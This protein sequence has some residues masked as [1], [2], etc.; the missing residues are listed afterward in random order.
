MNDKEETTYSMAISFEGCDPS[1]SFVAG[2]ECGMID[3]M[4]KN[5]EPIDRT[6]H[7]INE[8]QIRR[9]AHYYDYKIGFEPTAPSDDPDG[10][11]LFM[12]AAPVPAGEKIQ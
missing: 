9:I 7:R 10:T 3:Q 11:W 1:P 6:V 12:K 5:G 8:E 2:Y 4:M